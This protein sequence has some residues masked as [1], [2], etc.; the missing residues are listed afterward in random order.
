[1]IT[2]LAGKARHREIVFKWSGTT[3]AYSTS[4]TT[5]C[6]RSRFVLFPARTRSPLRPSD[7]S[8]CLFH[9]GPCAGA[10][11][12][13]EQYCWQ[14]FASC[15]EGG[16]LRMVVRSKDWRPRSGDVV[17]ECEVEVLETEAKE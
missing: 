2:P 12:T 13:R 15:D 8:A 9:L 6:M 14:C 5:S 10:C 1:M 3:C 4:S 7:G 17:E 16:A 11:L